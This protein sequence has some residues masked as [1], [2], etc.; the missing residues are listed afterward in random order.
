VPP[1][2]QDFVSTPKVVSNA[3][4]VAVIRGAAALVA[5]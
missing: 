3:W 5:V 1:K 4:K 2:K